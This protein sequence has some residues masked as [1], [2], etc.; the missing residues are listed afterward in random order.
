MLA[1]ALEGKS[2][3]S[4]DAGE[5]VRVAESSPD[6]SQKL[7]DVLTK[8]GNLAPVVQAL[9][10][11]EMKA[12]MQLITSEGDAARGEGI[13]RRQQLLCATCHAIGGAG[14]VVG[15]DMI[16][17]GASAPVDYIIES[18][19]EPNKKIKEGYHMTM[20]TQ[21][22]GEIAAGSVVRED[23]REV[24]LRDAGGNEVR[25]PADS[26]ASREVSPVS[27]MPVGLTASLRKDEF[28][29]LVKFLSMLGKEGGMRVSSQRLVRR[30]RAVDYHE[31]LSEAIR[32]SGLTES[33]IAEPSLPWRPAYSMVDGTLPTAGLGENIGFN[34]SRLSLVKFEIEVTTAGLVKFQSSEPSTLQMR[35]GKTM[36]DPRL[37]EVDLPVGRHEIVVIIDRAARGDEPLS[38]EL[39]DAEGSTAQARIVS[40]I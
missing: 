26:I 27:M 31:P 21:K 35:V 7:I 36:I 34:N 1:A 15:P 37:G 23:A 12:M 4:Q 38:V 6:R 29:D 33:V 18:L 39:L 3:R 10:D 22:S 24:V 19:L 17:V 30:W 40:G 14:G 28:V 11:E 16:S 20:L 2:I 9:S 25:V 5:G 8:A 32:R 13:Y